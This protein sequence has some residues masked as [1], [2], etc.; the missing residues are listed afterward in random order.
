MYAEMVPKMLQSRAWR[1]PGGQ[2]FGF[3]D[4]VD[5]GCVLGCA[6]SRPKMIK[7]RHLGGLGRFM[8]QLLG[9]SAAEAV[10]LGTWFY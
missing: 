3:W 8:A 9:G 7:V 4:A 10:V 5:F 2:L 1:R 6:K